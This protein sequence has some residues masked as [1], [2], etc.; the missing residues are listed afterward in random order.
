MI[1]AGP[2]DEDPLPPDGGNP[3]PQP[4]VFDDFDIWHAQNEGN[5]P[6]A[7]AQPAPANINPDEPVLMTPENSHVHNNDVNVEDVVMYDDAAVPDFFVAPPAEHAAENIVAAHV[8]SPAATVGD[9][10]PVA[11]SEEQTGI[12]GNNVILDLVDNHENNQLAAVQNMLANI[13]GS[14]NNI[15]PTITA[16][17][18]VG[19][20]CKMVTVETEHGLQDR[21]FLQ[22]NTESYSPV[23]AHSSVVIEEI[24]EPAVPPVAARKRKAKAP[25]SVAAVRRS[26]RIEKL[27]GGYK[28]GKSSA[29]VST[30]SF[31]AAIIDSAA[32]PPPHLP[33]DTL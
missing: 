22:I 32:P 24:V 31:S 15:L 33:K 5:N 17:K 8:D 2:G 7:P 23:Q 21:S 29:G 10:V 4:L 6:A 28:D 11:H 18:I 26:G 16:S 27:K 9:H 14:V 3:H 20:T 12:D 13:V 25:I 19:A 30:T 1:G